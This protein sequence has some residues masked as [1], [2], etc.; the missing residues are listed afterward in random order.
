MLFRSQ[1][2]SARHT[3]VFLGWILPTKG[4]AELIQAW[5]ELCPRDWD[6]WLVGP[7]EVEY[8]Q[9]VINHYQPRNVRFVSELT[10]DEA[11]QVLAGADLFVLPSYTEGFPNVILEAMALGKPIVATKVGAIQDMLSNDS[12]LLIEPKDVNGLRGALAQLIQDE[13]L[14]RELGIRAYNKVRQEYAV[15]AIFARY[16]QTWQSLMR[17]GT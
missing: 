17:S 16:V 6:L 2:Q 12:G 10:H 15:D 7:G 9:S 5:A 11:M 3:A 1:N 13:D 14:R 8:Q 4:V